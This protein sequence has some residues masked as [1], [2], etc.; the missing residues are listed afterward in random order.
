MERHSQQLRVGLQFKAVLI[1][2]LLMIAVTVTGEW[3]YLENARATLRRNDQNHAIRLIESVAA[4]VQ[5]HLKNRQI[6]AMEALAKD[7][8][9]NNSVRFVAILDI[10]GRPVASASGDSNPE[11]WSGL[12]VLPTSVSFTEQLSENVLVLARAVVL[13]EEL[14]EEKRTVGAVRLV[15]DTSRTTANLA[16]VQ[17]RMTLVT[18]A[19]VLCALPIG[20]LLVWRV[21]VQ[22]IRRLVDVTQRLSEGDFNA[23]AGFNRNDEVG[24]LAESFDTM[25]AEVS[26]MRN[27]LIDSNESLEMQIAE[28]TEQIQQANLLLRE[29]ISEKEDF[30]RAV[31]HDL[32][33]PL[34][35]ISGM[36]TLILMKWCD[37]LPEEVVGRL[38]RIRVNVDAEESLISELLELSRIRSRPQRR[39]LVDMEQLMK[40]LEATFEFELK[41]REI[42]LRIGTEMPTLFVEK[43]RIRQV[44][45]NLIDNAI[46]YMNRHEG[47]LIEVSYSRTDVD[48]VFAVVD[49]GPGISPDEQKRIFQ[50]FC[51]SESPTAANVSGKGVGLA[52]VKSVMG[53]YH[54][55]AWVESTP[56][57]GSAFFFTLDIENTAT[58][59]NKVSNEQ[60]EEQSTVYPVN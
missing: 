27:E 44:F 43:N 55:R 42:E 20:Y 13:D 25:A 29:E 49:N 16:Q 14:F 21:L 9:T 54:G 23:R 17:W 32:N 50:V 30:L 38:E 58:P 60:I 37:E 46:K 5:Y 36:A 11:E 33:A 57:E 34:R 15:I 53:N 19:I 1:L 18:F 59:E 22:P 8:V 6:E 28:R 52:L 51:R 40:D 7:L 47:G 24:D 56:G 35:N 39:K 41:A 12:V 31:S 45:Q 2:A 26:R 4:S 10:Q 48:H 3:F